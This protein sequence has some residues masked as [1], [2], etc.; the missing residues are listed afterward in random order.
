[1]KEAIFITGA[2][3]LVG[4]N[5]IP[6]TL[7]LKPEAGMILLIRGESYSRAEEKFNHLLNYLAGQLD[8]PAALQQ[9]Y[10]IW[11]DITRPRLGLNNFLYGKLVEQTTHIIHAAAEVRFNLTLEDAR[12]V[13]YIGTQNIIQLAKDINDRGHLKRLG[14][15]GTAFISGDRKGEILETE[16]DC[17]QLFFNS[18]E[19]SKF[20]A[21]CYI[22][23][24]TENL[25]VIIFR[26]SII[27]GDS[28]TGATC[29][30]NV[31]YKPLRLICN[32]LVRFLPGS[33]R[34][35]LDIV[36]VDYVCDSVCHLMFRRDDA[37]GRTFHITAG[38]YY[39]P[40]VGEVVRL[41]LDYFSKIFGSRNIK[42]VTFFP[43]GWH[44][45]LKR[46]YPAKYRRLDKAL[47]EYE[48]YLIVN[49]Q[50]NNT[51][52]RDALRGSGLRIPKFS[53][54]YELL[55]GYCRKTAWGK[56]VSRA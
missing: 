4:R 21:E 2:T 42:R 43:A 34:T 22:Q 39:S 1:M 3:G 40:D 30:F 5:L 36:P 14:Y 12:A 35:K 56:Q 9:I 53:E 17:G 32:G 44:K 37:V 46:Y 24:N 52:T 31:I 33:R 29:N 18:Y 47:K 7:K 50:F 27:V 49:R 20:E 11:G 13:N 38:K 51:N 25:P 23:K 55:L 41:S 28:K 26:P 16:L 45:V 8:D 15:I 19:Q 10:W 6:R 54:Y 48:P